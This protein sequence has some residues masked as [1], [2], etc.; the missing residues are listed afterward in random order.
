MTQPTSEEFVGNFLEH[1][2]I[3]GMKWGH[4]KDK[5]KGSSPH[6]NSRT[7]RDGDSDDF[8]RTSKI[9]IQAKTG[10]L[11]SL[12]N[13]EIRDLVD[14]INLEQ[15]FKKATG[16]E[17]MGKN[18]MKVGVT[19]ISDKLKKTGD[20]TVDALLRT[21]VNVNVEQNKSKMVLVPKLG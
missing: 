16:P 13:R 5:S 20:M 1:F 10:G 17:E 12:S 3:R 11:R 7:A 9:A 4:R 14:R 6:S 21:A 8:Q 15:N 2:G 18:P 19:Y